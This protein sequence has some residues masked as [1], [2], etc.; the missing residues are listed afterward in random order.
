[1]S[2]YI[3]HCKIA[4]KHHKQDKRNYAHTYHYADTICIAKAF[5]R[6]PDNFKWGIILHELGHLAGA[7]KE[8]EADKLAYEL[9][10]IR[11][12]RVDSKYGNCLETI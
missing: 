11:I 10:G 8:P 2:I 6:L 5:N 3:E 4:D 7:H 1:M 12:Y 9:Y